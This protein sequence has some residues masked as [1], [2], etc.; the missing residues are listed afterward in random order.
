MHHHGVM[1]IHNTFLFL[2]KRKRQDLFTLPGVFRSFHNVIWTLSSS[3]CYPHKHRDYSQE[4]QFNRHHYK[5]VVKGNPFDLIS[6]SLDA[7]CM[8]RDKNK[9]TTTS[10]LI[11]KNDMVLW[12]R[13]RT[14]FTPGRYHAE[15]TTKT[16]ISIQEAV[17]ETFECKEHDRA[18]RQPPPST[19]TQRVGNPCSCGLQGQQVFMV[20]VATGSERDACPNHHIN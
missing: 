14:A 7:S 15:H 16:S 10:T 5:Q 19:H 6:L 9:D 8:K 3:Q 13:K 11:C 20:P 4:L 2:C 18:K 12:E 1:I 17:G